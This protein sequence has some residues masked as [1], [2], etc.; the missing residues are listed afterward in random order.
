MEV[1]MHDVAVSPA[2]VQR[3]GEWTIQTDAEL[4]RQLRRWRDDRL[5]NETGG[6]LI[7]HIDTS[8]KIIYVFDALPS[9]PDSKEW[10]TLY[11]RGRQGLT[12]AVERLT[13]ETGGMA[14]YLGEW[15]THPGGITPSDDDKKVLVWLADYLAPVGR[16]AIIAIVGEGDDAAFYV[17]GEETTE[18]VIDGT[19]P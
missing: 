10:P 13:R 12:Q 15:H 17:G 14:E 19:A 7:G 8:R 1:E 2:I 9:P 6:V 16:P 4:L 18:D 5:P 3:V 11:I